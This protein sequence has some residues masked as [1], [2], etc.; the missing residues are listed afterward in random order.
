MDTPNLAAGLLGP[1]PMSSVQTAAGMSSSWG[2]PPPTGLKS[3]LVSRHNNVPLIMS[4]FVC[5]EEAELP[6]CQK[7]ISWARTRS[8]STCT[9]HHI[10][11]CN[12][13]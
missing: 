12:L 8:V 4:V 7:T 6:V 2:E 5:Q 3:G 10:S 9:S 13:C 11:Q 1:A